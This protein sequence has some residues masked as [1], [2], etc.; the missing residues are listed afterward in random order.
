MAFLQKIKYF[1]TK[2]IIKYFIL[3]TIKTCKINISGEEEIKKLK[4]NNIPVIHIFWHR[5]IFFT[6]YKFRN[7]G[8]QPLVSLS[9]DGELVSNVAEEF[10]MNPVRGS[11]SKGG[12][13]AFLE[14]THS[15]K[16]NKSE[17]LITADGPKGP[18]EKIK[19]GT[20]LLAQKTNSVIVPISWYA[21]RVKI[22][23]KSWDK[24]LVPLPFSKIYFS[25]GNP[26]YIN[27]DKN[28]ITELKKELENE[29]KRL[30]NECKNSSSK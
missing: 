26:F 9:K 12:A 29:L 30:E 11:S 19:D 10:G 24:F 28:D 21:N 1:L 4:K 13:R 3:F 18:P 23:E 20:I 16:K 15:I 17:I 14:L 7:V 27:K 22:F 2:K 8:A 6:I 25:F 5:H